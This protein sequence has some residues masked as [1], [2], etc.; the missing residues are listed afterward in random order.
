MRDLSDLIN[1][2]DPAWPL[3]Q[4]WIGEASVD[5]ET[6]P[7][8]S[9]AG[10]AALHAVQVTTGSSMGAITLNV[11]GILIDSGWLRVLGAGG[12]SRF[13]RSLPGWNAGRSSGFYLV[14]DDAVGGFFALNGGAL[15]ED[16]GNIYF[17][18]LDSLQWEA[19]KFGYSQFLVWAM[20]SNLREFYHSLRWN[21]WQA[22][23]KKL[24]A[25]QAISIFPFLFTN[26]PPIEARNRGLV[27][28][29]EQYAL[30]F[31]IQRQLSGQ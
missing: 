18:A 31:D 5:V 19:C 22:E 20:S 12:H 8:D 23:V 7:A 2:N 6:L 28:V 1:H 30:Q 13:Q 11:A 15:G 29:A 9:A 24:T 16:L 26:G 4:K 17:Y 21:G 10:E 14:A 25:D 3:V 27:P